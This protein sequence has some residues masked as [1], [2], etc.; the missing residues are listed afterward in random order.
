MSIRFVILFWPVLVV[1]A[2][3]FAGC[4]EMS[5]KKT[6]TF[7]QKFGWKAEDYFDDSQVIRA[8]PCH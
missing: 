4:A 7:H 2:P 5:E 6:E 1:I 8:L 3:L